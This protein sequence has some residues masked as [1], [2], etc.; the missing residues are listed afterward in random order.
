MDGCNAFERQ[1][2][3]NKKPFMCAPASYVRS[4]SCDGCKNE[5]FHIIPSFLININVDN[6]NGENDGGVLT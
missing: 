6:K 2:L 1:I 3:L 4:R 5:K